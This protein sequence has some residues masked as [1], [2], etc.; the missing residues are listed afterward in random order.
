[1]GSVPA[2]HRM[3]ITVFRKII[4]KKQL[5]HSDSITGSSAPGLS[6]NNMNDL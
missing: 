5:I 2:E 3:M 6:I 1:M 4:K